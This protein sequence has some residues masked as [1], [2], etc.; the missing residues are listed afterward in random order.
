MELKNSFVIVDVGCRWGF[1]DKFLNTNSILYGFDPDEEECKRIEMGYKGYNVKVVPSALAEEEGV[2]TLFHTKEPACSSFYKPNKYLT[3]NFPSLECAKEVGSSEIFATTLDKWAIREDIK[4]IDYMKLDTQ[5]SELD[6]L[7]GGI[8]ILN[9]IRA[10]EI[11]VEFNPIYDG[12]HLFSD[13]DLFM[14]S[15]GFTL[16][17]LSNM[18]HYFDINNKIP[19]I[20]EDKVFYG[21]YNTKSFVTHGGQLFWADAHYVKNEVISNSNTSQESMLSDIKLMNMIGLTDVRD[22]LERRLKSL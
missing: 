15:N 3:E 19:E 11:E 2:K 17:K 21:D 20:G 8:K 1:A 6:I 10:I 22:L 18:V 13:V 14:R 16:W 5:G 12:Q 4:N 7:M 9:T